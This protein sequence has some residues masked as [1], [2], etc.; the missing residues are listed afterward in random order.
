MLDLTLSLSIGD[1]RKLPR[2]PSAGSSG[3][4]APSSSVT[5]PSYIFSMLK[6]FDDKSKQPLDEMSEIE[7]VRGK[8]IQFFPIN[9]ETGNN[10]RGGCLVSQRNEGLDLN[11]NCMAAEDCGPANQKIE[12]QIQQYRP[13]VKKNRRGPRT[14]SSQYRGVTFYRRTGRWESHIWDCG[15]GR[16]VYLG[17]FDTAPAAARAYDLAAIRFRGAE[18]YLNFDLANYREDVKYMNSLTKDEFVMYLRSRIPATLDGKV[19]L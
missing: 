10:G 14:T 1:S 18:A 4:S 16:Q 15:T 9:T 3:H 11:L 2:H 12:P 6:E 13:P 17:G 19:A 5:P 7:N 8:T